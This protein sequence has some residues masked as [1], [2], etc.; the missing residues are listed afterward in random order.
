MRCKP[1]TRRTWQSLLQSRILPHFG[2]LLLHD[3]TRTAVADWFDDV[4]LT[5]PGNANRGLILLGQ[6]LNCAVRHGLLQQN[7]TTGL[8]KNRGRRMTRFLSADE[9]ARL[10]R[11][12]DAHV[13]EY[14]DD[15]RRCGHDII[16]LLILTG[17]RKGEILN[18]IIGRDDNGNALEVIR[19][20]SA[21]DR[22][23]GGAGDDYIDAG[24]G[25][26]WIQA[27]AGPNV[28]TGG[29]GGDVFVMTDRHDVISQQQL[30]SIIARAKRI[31]DFGVVGTE[32][33]QDTLSFADNVTEIWVRT[34][35]E[36]GRVSSLI[37]AYD[38]T[39]E[40]EQNYTI[41]EGYTGDITAAHLGSTDI[42][43]LNLIIGRDDNGNALEVIRGTSANDRIDGGTGEDYITGGAGKDVLTGGAGRD[44]F[45]IK[46]GCPR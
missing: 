13:A 46:G 42:R 12:M 41:L 43:I 37:T 9:L 8:R 23:D 1:S 36:N 22:I 30:P 40:Q 27:G 19:G 44:T 33:G 21:N 20:T 32:G 38:G 10:Y 34:I 17:C 14:P 3:I 16:R 7:V 29:T 45:N 35:T 15:N 28:L 2:Q 4:S 6:I 24:A 26:D 11:A 31:T 39:Q 18:L 5:T 25:N